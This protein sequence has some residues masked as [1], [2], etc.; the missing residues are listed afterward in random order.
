VE[1]SAFPSP[2]CGRAASAQSG[3]SQKKR[4]RI[5]TAIGSEHRSKRSVAYID[6]CHQVLPPLPK[7]QLVLDA[8]RY[9]LHSVFGYFVLITH[10]SGICV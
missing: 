4:V 10:Q 5:L 9:D 8:L 2:S 6:D 7:L 3:Q 1:G